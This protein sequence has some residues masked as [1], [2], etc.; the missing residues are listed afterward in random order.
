MN[1]R[2]L[3]RAE[4]VLFAIAL[5]TAVANGKVPGFLAAQNTSIS[6][7]ITDKT[8][9][10][11]AADTD[12]VNTRLAAQE[13]TAVADAYQKELLD[14]IGDVLAG[15]K[16]TNAAPAVYEALGFD[17]PDTIKT[18]TVPERPTAL[19]ADASTSGKIRLTW[20]SNNG[21]RRITFPIEAKIGDTAPWA[22]IGVSTTQKWT[23]EPTVAGQYYEYRVRAQAAR[24]NFS[25]YS[26]N[27]VIYGT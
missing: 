14:L 21:N 15:L 7:A 12:V 18:N 8:A 17:A 10:L 3:S 13:A 6:D 27:F 9:Q 22:L 23:H 2:R 1:Y 24:N 16:M 19:L 20:K 5:A 4:L 26:N 11:S 25:D